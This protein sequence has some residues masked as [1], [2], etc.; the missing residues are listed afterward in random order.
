MVL[1]KWC[2]FARVFGLVVAVRFFVIWLLGL[3]IDIPFTIVGIVVIIIG[4]AV[5]HVLH[6]IECLELRLELIKQCLLR[7]LL[8]LHLFDELLLL[9]LFRLNY[10]LRV[11]NFVDFAVH[12]IFVEVIL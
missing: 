12:F 5:L 7:D 2:H 4:P 8:R 3:S 1:R 10:I 11:V 6:I 9:L